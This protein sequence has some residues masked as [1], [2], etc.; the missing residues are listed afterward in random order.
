MFGP[1][2]HLHEEKDR[3]ICISEAKRVCKS[4]GT[5]FFAFINNDMVFLT[6]LRYSENFF[7]GDTYN[8]ST[9]KLEDFPFV[10]FTVSQCR[11]MLLNGGVHI[12]N[13]IASDGVSELIDEKINTMNDE[14]YEQYLR[15]HFYVCEKTE[16]LGRSNHLLF[17]GE[18]R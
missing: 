16:M 15:Y 13:E 12:I 10:F 18:K 9:F 1:L 17:I 4:D 8:H 14:N 5:L 6:E 7:L 11:E 3:Q 2:Y